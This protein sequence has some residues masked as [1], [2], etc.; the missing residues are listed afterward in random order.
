MGENT[1]L[2]IDA[3]NHCETNSVKGLLII[4][5]CAKAF[6]TLELPFIEYCLRSFGFRNYIIDVVRSLQTNSYSRIEQNGHFFWENP[7]IKR[8]VDRGTISPYLFVSCTC[9]EVLPNIIRESW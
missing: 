4:V 6:D 5:D 3:L 9:A 8:A 1:C 2:L 7:I